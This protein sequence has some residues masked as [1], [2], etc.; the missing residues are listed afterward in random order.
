MKGLA[1]PFVPFFTPLEYHVL[2]GDRTEP[3]KQ[4]AFSVVTAQGYDLY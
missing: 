4:R 2:V 3:K 1:S